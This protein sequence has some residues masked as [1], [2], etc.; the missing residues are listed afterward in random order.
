MERLAET[1]VRRRIAVFV[2][3]AIL[4]AI[5]GVFAAKLPTD[6]NVAAILPAENPDVVFFRVTGER[7]GTNFVNMSALEADDLFT[8]ENLTTLRAMTNAAADVRGVKFAMSVT[9]LLDMQPDGE[10]SI[11]VREIVP[12]DGI[13]TEAAELDHIRH[14]VLDNDMLAGN[15]ASPDGKAALITIMLEP[16]QDPKI[17]GAALKDAIRKAA[18]G[19]AGTVYFGG[20][21]MIVD[22]LGKTIGG[23][24]MVIT[25]SLTF[26]VF[27]VLLG[28][29]IG[30]VLG[31]VASLATAG[32]ATLWSLGA[33]GAMGVTL[34]LFTSMLPLLVIVVAVPMATL[35]AR[36]AARAKGTGSERTV[37][38]VKQ[39]GGAALGAGFVTALASLA[40][41]AMDLPIFQHIGIGL[42]IGSASAGILAV[43]LAPALLSFGGEKEPAHSIAD[44][45]LGGITA[46]GVEGKRAVLLPVALIVLVVFGFLAT[47]VSRDVNP[48]ST[49]PAGSEPVETE[50]LMQRGFGGSQL[51]QIN[52]H[53]ADVRHPAVLEQM[54]LA[55]RR[56]LNIKNVN[57]PQS[58]ADVLIMLNTNLNNEPS[59]PDEIDKINNM[60]FMLEGQAQVDMLIDRAFTD[61]VVQ[62]RI[63]D[64]DSSVVGP[65]M[66]KINEVVDAVP[67]KLVSVSL[68]DRPSNELG[69]WSE[70]LAERAVEKLGLDVRRG[71]DKDIDSKDLTAGLAALRSEKPTIDSVLRSEI[72]DRYAAY[73]K[74][75]EAD[76]VLPDDFDVTPTAEALAFL[77]DP[78]EP[79]VIDVLKEKLPAD[80]LAEDPAGPTYAA[81]IL[82]GIYNKSIKRWRHGEA[83]KLAREKINGLAEAMAKD[84]SLN[85]SVSSSLWT[86]NSETANV[87]PQ[88]YEEITGEAPQADNVIELQ[89]RV[90]GWPQVND[91][92]HRALPKMMKAG[93]FLALILLAVG[94]FIGT[95]TLIGTVAALL[96]VTVTAVVNLGL[97]TILG[98]PLD[99]ITWVIL[100]IAVGLASSSALAVVGSRRRGLPLPAATVGAMMLPVA[101]GFA[102]LMLAE[103]GMQALLGVF[104]AVS[105]LAALT[106]SLAIVP[107][108][109]GEDEPE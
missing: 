104:I 14:L 101:V 57:Y 11:S 86:I 80:V 26:G 41:L 29:F 51:F 82:V 20:V 95:R 46:A 3:V 102:F 108:L 10:G 16:G 49:F 69:K 30:R 54:D 45:L 78:S 32:L 67:H 48:M 90:T 4:S 40:S 5:A 33:L 18:D 53:S 73:L 31:L 64:I 19:R 21:E 70:A 8:N 92:L 62:A 91:M 65:A 72:Q 43:T 56:L 76:I 12:A 44:R 27:I 83:L 24:G 99:N 79:A 75:D 34:N 63:G 85:A 74:S 6:M 39:F 42:A 77:D 103:L 98:V 9:N 97:M 87:T 81:P 15:L 88:K 105:A 60:W 59:T 52:V 23:T 22:F 84:P 71:L 96:C 61:A 50:N 2:A 35:I 68:R 107:G 100:L 58:I 36:A 13:P 25:M 89:A 106:A 94:L 38:A 93:G 66:E 47:R 28:L 55:K 37:I 109:V 7:F 1:V 17:M